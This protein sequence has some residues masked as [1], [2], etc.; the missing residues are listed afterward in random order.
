MHIPRLAAAIAAAVLG[1]SDPCTASATA[2][3]GTDTTLFVHTG[4]GG[5]DGHPT[6]N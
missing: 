3:G 2:A 4:F 6:Q 5:D 1:M